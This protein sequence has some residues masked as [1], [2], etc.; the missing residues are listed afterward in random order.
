VGGPGAQWVNE[1]RGLWTLTEEGADKIVRSP[2][3]KIYRSP[4]DKL[5]WSADN[6]AH[7]G[8]AFK[9]YEETGQGLQWFKDADQ[10]GDFISGK[11]KG[12]TGMFIPWSQTSGVK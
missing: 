10:F 2:F 8:S 11:H 1:G 7:G 12:P 9:V 6:A 5:W 4:S 3:G